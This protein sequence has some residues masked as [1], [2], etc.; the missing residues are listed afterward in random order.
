MLSL[1]AT[2]LPAYLILSGFIRSG[3]YTELLVP[4]AIAALVTNVTVQFHHFLIHQ[5]GKT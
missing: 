4:L 1:L 2:I 3:Y 5:G